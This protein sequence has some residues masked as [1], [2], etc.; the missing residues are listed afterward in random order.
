MAEAIIKEVVVAEEAI[1]ITV[2]EA[3]PVDGVLA[4]E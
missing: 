2:T 1:I 4:E 3:V